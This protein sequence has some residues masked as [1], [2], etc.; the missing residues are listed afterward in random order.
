LD[1]TDITGA[2]EK[3]GTTVNN[4]EHG[5]LSPIFIHDK[6]KRMSIS[7]DNTLPIQTLP[8]LHLAMY[9]PSLLR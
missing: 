6:E 1:A 2:A 4:S 7:S 9:S 8:I 5:D 3:V